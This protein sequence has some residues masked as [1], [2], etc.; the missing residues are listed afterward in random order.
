MRQGLVDIL[1][2]LGF[3]AFVYGLWLMWHPLAWCVGGL[4]LLGYAL[5]VS[6]A[7]PAPDAQ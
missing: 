2:L 3:A 1:G 6:R 5:R 4:L 7:T